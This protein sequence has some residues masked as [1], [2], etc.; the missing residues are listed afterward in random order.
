VC[1]EN[2]L[3]ESGGRKMYCRCLDHRGVIRLVNTWLE[4]CWR[5]VRAELFGMLVERL[6]IYWGNYLLHWL[7][8]ERWRRR[9]VVEIVVVVVTALDRRRA[10]I[11]SSWEGEFRHT[12]I[13]CDV[14]SA[15]HRW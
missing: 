10:L 4:S 13:R 5:H 14:R 12:F 7:R 15:H 2:L 3:P 9:Y 1:G 11:A 8:V 6:V